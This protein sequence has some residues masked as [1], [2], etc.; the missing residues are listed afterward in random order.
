M[1]IDCYSNDQCRRSESEP[2]PHPPSPILAV[3]DRVPTMGLILILLVGGFSISCLCYCRYRYITANCRGAHD[4]VIGSPHEDMHFYTRLG[5]PSQIEED[6]ITEEENQPH[7]NCNSNNGSNSNRGNDEGTSTGDIDGAIAETPEQA[8]EQVGNQDTDPLQPV[9]SKQ[10]GNQQQQQE[11]EQEPNGDRDNPYSLIDDEQHNSNNVNRH[12]LGNRENEIEPLLHPSFNNSIGLAEQP[13]NIK[14]SHT[15]YSI[16]Y[17]LSIFTIALI[18]GMSIFFFPQMPVFNVCNDEVAWAQ[19]MKNIIT[20]KVDAGFEILASLS[21]PNGIA[22]ALDEGKGSFSFDGKQFGT[23]AIPPIVVE[24]MSITDLMIIVHISPADKS[25][26][27]QLAEAY[28]MGKLVLDAEFEGTIR[29][30]DVFNYT[31]NVAAKNI[32][33]DINEI[34]D[35]SLCH[36]PTWDDD[37]N[38]STASLLKVMEDQWTHL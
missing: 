33:V 1:G 30:P 36:C 35:R 20:F 32:I 21:N 38:H 16:L 10:I 12:Q 24:P 37:K 8:S 26:A 3:L 7:A 14:Q 9:A 23:F 18:V 19:I 34:G 11:Q 29:V 25:Q 27:I 15:C 2:L 5:E 28:Y 4:D 31:R 22:A 17:C 6:V 13:H